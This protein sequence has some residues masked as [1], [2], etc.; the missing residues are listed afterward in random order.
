[1]KA[2][3]GREGVA[4]LIL[5]TRHWMENRGCKSWS[6]QVTCCLLIFYISKIFFTANYKKKKSTYFV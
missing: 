2:Y 1:M 5:W 3:R 4:P 6:Q